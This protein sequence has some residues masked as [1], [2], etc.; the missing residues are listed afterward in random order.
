[1]QDLRRQ[2]GTDGN[3]GGAA[4]RK[5][6][7]GSLFSGAGGFDVGLE[8]AGFETVW[9]VEKDDFNLKVL[10]KHWPDVPKFTDVRECGDG[11]KHQLEPVDIISGGF[12]CQ[13]VSSAGKRRGLGTPD[14]PT[15]RSGLW[16]EFRRIVGEQR[17]RWVLIENVY[18]L[19]SNGADQV[20]AD[21]EHLG[22]ACWANV[23]GAENFGAPHERKRVWILCRRNDAPLA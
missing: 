11:R 18:R 3:G 5:L 4:P 22:Y 6:R 16:F 2:F 8:W 12:P 20:L 14:N 15:E 21:M 17:S 19:K 10:R 23:V 7:H 9:Q 1:M 13:D